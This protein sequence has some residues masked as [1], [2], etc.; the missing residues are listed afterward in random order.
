MNVLL[1]KVILVFFIYY[2]VL[3]IFWIGF[4]FNIYI[5]FFL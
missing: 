1:N 3:F 5:F 4:Y 2:Y